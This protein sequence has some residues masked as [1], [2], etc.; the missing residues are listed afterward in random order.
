M[1]KIQ[2][3][4]KYFFLFIFFIPVT[5][6]KGH[7]KNLLPGKVRRQGTRIQYEQGCIGGILGQKIRKDFRT[8]LR[9]FHS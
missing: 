1:I 3:D 8:S 4:Y 6:E 5:I 9:S 7:E 2:N